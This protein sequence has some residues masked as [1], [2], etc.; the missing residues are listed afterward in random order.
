MK[1]YYTGENVFDAAV[2]RIKAMYEGG[3]RVVF[4]FS[5]GKDSGVC[6]E[7]GIIA[8]R[9]TGNLPIE[10]VM[11][12]EEIMIP[13]TF[14]YS[15]RVYKRKSE[16]DFHWII[17]NQPVINIFNRELPYFW[18]FDPLLDPEKWVRQPPDWAE[19]IK[20]NNIEHMISPVRF[21]PPPGKE[22]ISVV[23]LRVQE[24]AKRRMGLLSSKG[25]LTKPN[26]LGV[27][28][29]RPIYDWTDADVWLAHKKL[30]W[31]YNSAYDVLNK[32]GVPRYALRIA[33]PTMHIHS[34]TTLIPASKAFPQ[35][36]DRV[37]DRLPGVKI[38]SQFGARA[39]IPLKMDR[40][41]WK[42]CF[43]RTCINEAPQWI[44]ERA[45]TVHDSVMRVH[46]K[47]STTPYPEIKPCYYCTETLGSWKKLTYALYNGDPFSIKTKLHQVE[48]EYFRKGSGIWGGRASF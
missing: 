19:Y 41:T 13:G 17:A 8:A 23:G 31:D 12:D 20:E 30:H 36:F 44:R 24:S 42:Q 40:E 34:L 35:W 48:P 43:F 18:V 16:I 9:E 22:L 46:V 37:C 10:V 28:Y 45:Q 1:R 38:V 33:P 26:H 4:S 15:E 32:M 14:E 39:V 21:P 11:R 27:R 5:G 29:A 3:N 7:L 25:Y 2:N 6:L 47:H